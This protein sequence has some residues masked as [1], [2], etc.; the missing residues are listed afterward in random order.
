MYK[1]RTRLIV[2][3]SLPLLL[4]ILTTACNLPWAGTP[5][6]TA[7]SE[8]A[9]ATAVAETVQAQLTLE[10]ALQASSSPTNTS[11][12]PPPEESATPAVSDTPAFTPTL[13]VPIL[14]ADV[15]TNCRLGPSTLYN[16]PVSVL[17]KGKESEVHGRNDAGT[18][19]YIRD[20][21]RAD[22]FCWIW[23]ETTRVDGDV[24]GL[25]VI[26]PPPP[27]PTA[28]PTATPAPAFS[29]SYETVHSCDGNPTAIF[30]VR[31]TGTVAFESL[32][33]E[34]EDL[35]DSDTLFGPSSS[36]APFMGAS[37]ECPPGGDDLKAGKTFFVGG[38]IG[39]GNSGHEARAT[40][41]LC[42]E[43]D[44]DGVCVEKRVNFTIP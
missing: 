2:F 5:A 14:R 27:P 44:L 34:I 29:A 22:K 19:W 43:D 39:A 13:T 12:P 42:T 32:N 41:E 7:V 36:D 1:P 21:E 9:M 10:A 16:P 26:T 40:I 37:S 6:P 18:W 28:T 23:G 24:G 11:S 31:N 33:L 30:E 15:N 25:P 20:P 38:A 3:L 17:L 8:D 35:T 4:A